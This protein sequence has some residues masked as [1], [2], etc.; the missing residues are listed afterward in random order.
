MNQ[1]ELETVF[2]RAARLSK[3]D[4]ISIVAENGRRSETKLAFQSAQVR[5]RKESC[6]QPKR[7]FDS[8]YR[9]FVLAL[10]SRISPAKTGQFRVLS[11][12]TAS[13]QQH[14]QRR[15]YVPILS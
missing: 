12:V 15:C 10:P 9:I 5:A 4:C 2:W 8:Y 1:D 6:S 14:G 11:L 13:F 7:S 3:I